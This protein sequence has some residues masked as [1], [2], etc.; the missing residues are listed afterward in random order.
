[1]VSAIALDLLRNCWFNAS[2][3]GSIV[4]FSGGLN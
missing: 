4:R 2:E 3:R 1:M